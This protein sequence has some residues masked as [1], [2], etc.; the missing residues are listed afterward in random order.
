MAVGV[1]LVTNPSSG[2]AVSTESLADG[3]A[4][5]LSGCCATEVR[6]LRFF[7]GQHGCD[8]FVD[9]LGSN[10]EADVLEHHRDRQNR[11]ERVGDTLA[12]DVGG[13][14]VDWPIIQKIKREE[15]TD[16]ACNIQV[17]AAVEFVYTVKD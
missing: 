10:V 12:G 3:M 16:V 7:S 2:L 11:G 15:N 1:T 9:R 13:R 4:D 14:A 5:M 6:R 17:L 8:C